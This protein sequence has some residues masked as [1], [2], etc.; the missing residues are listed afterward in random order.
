MVGENCTVLRL[1][2][3]HKLA[4]S[5]NSLIDWPILD[6]KFNFLILTTLS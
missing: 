4:M 1:R 2:L 6:L 3:M 5:H